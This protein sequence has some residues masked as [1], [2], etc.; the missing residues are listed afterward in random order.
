MLPH[1]LQGLYTLLV[2]VETIC[3]DIPFPGEGEVTQ[4]V[5]HDMIFDVAVSSAQ[6]TLDDF[7]PFVQTFAVIPDESFTSDE[8]EVFVTQNNEGAVGTQRCV[9]LIELHPA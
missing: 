7:K 5:G 6:P 3:E 9:L 4:G 8:V 1:S 2:H